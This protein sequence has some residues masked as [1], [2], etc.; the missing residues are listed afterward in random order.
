MSHPP[1]DANLPVYS[2]FF[3]VKTTQITRIYVILVSPDSPQQKELLFLESYGVHDIIRRLLSF[4]TTQIKQL[5]MNPI[6]NDG[7]PSFMLQCYA[8]AATCLI[9][10]ITNR[11]TKTRHFAKHRVMLMYFLSEPTAKNSLQSQNQKSNNN[12]P[13][14]H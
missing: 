1:S 4:S 7:Y 11:S 13:L 14:M 3:S 9:K 10:L 8:T 6:K 5:Y 2:F 12:L